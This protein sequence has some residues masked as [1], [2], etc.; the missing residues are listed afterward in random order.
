MAPGWRRSKTL[1]SHR[2]S[3]RLILGVDMRQCSGRMSKVGGFLRVLQFPSSR[4]T[5][6]ANIR[7]F[8]NAFIS[9]VSFL[10]NRSKINGVLKRYQTSSGVN[11]WSGHL[12]RLSV[13]K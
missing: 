13:Q 12:I 7:A 5:T 3:P 6:N 11:D 2:C 1:A 9:Y 4:K 8:E 10:C